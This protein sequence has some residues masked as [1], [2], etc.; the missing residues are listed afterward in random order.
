MIRNYPALALWC[1]NNEILQ[2][3]NDWGW[4]NQKYR[5]DYHKLFEVLIRKIVEIEN[6]DIAYIPSSPVNGVGNFGFDRGGDIHFWGVWAGGSNFE[7]Y[8][9]AVGPFNSEFGTQALPVWHSIQ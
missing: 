7:A 3:I 9:K 2:G 8:E 5:E 1:G 4:G 6:P